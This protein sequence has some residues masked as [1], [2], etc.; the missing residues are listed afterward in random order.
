[1]VVP[2]AV[3]PVVEFHLEVMVVKE[4]RVHQVRDTTVR[5]RVKHGTPLAVE[6]LVVK[7]MVE[8]DKVVKMLDLT[9]VM[10]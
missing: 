4:V 10:V 6:V 9:V 8:T 1:M 7:V 3:V 5:D 2:V